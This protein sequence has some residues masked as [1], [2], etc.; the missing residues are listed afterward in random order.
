MLSAIALDDE[1]RALDILE[2][3]AKRLDLIVLN[4]SFTRPSDARE[5]LKESQ[6]DLLFLDI[7]MPAMSG[8]NFAKSLHVDIMVIFTTSY[9]EYAVEGF[10][11]KAVDYLLK[12]YSYGRFCQAVER[13]YHFHKANLNYSFDHL[14]LKVKHGTMQ[15]SLARIL[16]IEGLNNHIKIYLIDSE[17]I[18]VRMTLKGIMHELPKNGFIRVHRSFIVAKS[19]IDFVRNKIIFIQNQQIP[20]GGKYEKIFYDLFNSK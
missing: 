5:Y 6:I 18:V 15:V 13:A 9:S 14:L 20:V 8:I 3:F 19:R 12:P 10:N 16:F 1:T 7:N 11:L 17:A 4:A 2:A